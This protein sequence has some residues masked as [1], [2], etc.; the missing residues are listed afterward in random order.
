MK[1]RMRS[2]LRVV[3]AGVARTAIG[4]LAAGFWLVGQ[5]RY[6][7]DYCQTRAPQPRS[8]NPEGLSGR[9]GY[10]DK[11]VTVRCEY[12]QFPAVEVCLRCPLGVHHRLLSR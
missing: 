8:S 5:A 3:V 11:P 6:T 10:V 9:P 7:E 1:A 2:M 12:D 4:L